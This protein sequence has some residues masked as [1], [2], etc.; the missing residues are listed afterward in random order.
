MSLNNSFSGTSSGI[1]VTRQRE[2]LWLHSRSK[3]QQ[4]VLS[5]NHVFT[6]QCVNTPLHLYSTL[7]LAI[8]AAQRLNCGSKL[9]FLLSFLTSSVE[10]NYLCRWCRA[11]LKCGWGTAHDGSTGTIRDTRGWWDDP[12]QSWCAHSRLSLH[13]ALWCWDTSLLKE[14]KFLEVHLRQSLLHFLIHPT[15]WLQENSL[16]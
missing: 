15:E 3:N 5:A 4:N 16:N 6:S 11:L 12:G 13:S 14:R 2:C 8:R 9:S 1:V 7:H 10:W